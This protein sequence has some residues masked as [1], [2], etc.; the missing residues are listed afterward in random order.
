MRLDFTLLSNRALLMTKLQF[1]S[2]CSSHFIKLYLYSLANDVTYDKDLNRYDYVAFR[3][4]EKLL[5][6]LLR[7]SHYAENQ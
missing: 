6:Y 7:F 5:I 3:K 1:H 2:S 4:Q